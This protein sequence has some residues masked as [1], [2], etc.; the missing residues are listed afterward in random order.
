MRNPEIK[1]AFDTHRNQ[2]MVSLSFENLFIHHSP[3]ASFKKVHPF[4]FKLNF[5]QYFWGN[6]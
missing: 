1:L 5:F 2:A 6:D 4:S 3:T